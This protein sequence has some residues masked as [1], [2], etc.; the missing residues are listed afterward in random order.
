MSSILPAVENVVFFD[1]ESTGL[2]PFQNRIVSIQVRSKGKTTI[3]KEWQL[4]EIDC[5]E[6]FF[7]FA[8]ILNKR[9]TCLVGYNV[10]KFDVSFL[11]QRL[12]LL[13]RMNNWKW[14]IL[15]KSIHWIDLYQ[16]LGDAYCKASLWY[17][18]MLGVK[19]KVA[20]ADIPRLYAERSPDSLQNILDYIEEEMRSME[21]VY[22]RIKSESFYRELAE[23]RKKV[24]NE[25]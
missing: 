6:S 24:I 5:L 17:S 4:G 19:Q 22:E 10:L 20:N 7:D 3:W 11:D 16:F 25:N 12:R 14:Q 18:L 1:L 9:E 13:Q 2:D 21:L 15:H 8:N 23:L